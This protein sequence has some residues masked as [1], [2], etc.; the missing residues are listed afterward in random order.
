MR[1]RA[2]RRH[3][4]SRPERR[5]GRPCHGCRGRRRTRHGGRR[6]RP[7]H[8]RRGRMRRPSRS[9][10]LLG[11]RADARRDRGDTNK[12][13]CKASA[14]WK[15][16]RSS[17]VG[18]VAHRTQRESAR[19]VRPPAIAALRFYAAGGGVNPIRS[20]ESA[21]AAAVV[22]HRHDKSCFSVASIRSSAQST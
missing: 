17:P 20:R 3:G 9:F 13:R 1:H 2:R 16:D 21:A 15:H 5:C 19:I 6:R 7:S 22:R 14:T 8:R 11:V 12:E 18:P 10:P 4:R